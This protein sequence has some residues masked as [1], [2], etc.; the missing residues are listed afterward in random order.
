MTTRR[1]LEMTVRHLGRLFVLLVIPPLIGFGVATTLPRSYQC[2]AGLKALQRY[3]VINTAGVT[4]ANFQETPAQTQVDALDDDLTSAT[5]DLAVAQGTGLDDQ[6]RAAV[7][8]NDSAMRDAIFADL[9][10]HVLVAATGTNHYTITYTNKDKGVALAVVQSLI[11]QWTA[12]APSF[13]VLAGQKLLAD[14]QAQLAADQQALDAAVSAERAYA[15]AHPGSTVANDPTHAILVGNTSQAQTAVTTEH[16]ALT[17]LQAAVA[18]IGTSTNL[19][20]VSDPPQKP[21]RPVSRTK[22][23]V[24]GGGAGLAV[25]LVAA[26]LY[27]VLLLRRY[28]GLYSATDL[29]ALKVPGSP[30]LVIAEIPRL[31][32]AATTV[33][34][35]LLGAGASLDGNADSKATTKRRAGQR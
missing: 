5:F 26:A 16:D 9:S 15:Q 20:Q 28:R 27:L 8:A 34:A 22:T 21:Y 18:Q 32:R 25:G 31:P 6:A 35:R 12:Q 17:N 29:A 24:V 11:T 1:V 19:F 33:S 10:A 4:E 2:T 13:A 23:L 30:P 7:G 3:T 14:E